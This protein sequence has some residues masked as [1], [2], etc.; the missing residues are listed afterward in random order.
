MTRKSWKIQYVFHAAAMPV[1]AK[2]KTLGDCQKQST[3]NDYE[4][5]DK[6]DSETSEEEYS[7]WESDFAASSWNWWTHL[8]WRYQEHVRFSFSL[9]W[10]HSYEWG[11]QQHWIN[12]LNVY[13]SEFYYRFRLFINR[14]LFVHGL[15]CWS[16]VLFLEQFN[17]EK[18]VFMYVYGSWI[19]DS[20]GQKTISKD[21]TLSSGSL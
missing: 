13:F 5:K 6:D 21:M 7:D 2:L 16:I 3:N 20:Y 1:D 4:D 11:N 10:F 9:L 18:T 8:S 15:P 14:V 12:N 19:L 17:V